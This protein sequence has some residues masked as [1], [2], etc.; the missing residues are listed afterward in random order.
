[1]NYNSDYI[2]EAIH[3]GDD[4]EIK[5]S[6]NLANVQNFSASVNGTHV[7]INSEGI[8]VNGEPILIGSSGDIIPSISGLRIGTN[9]NRWKE[10]RGVS[11]TTN[12]DFVV[13]DTVYATGISAEV[14]YS[15]L[16]IQGGILVAVFS[17]IFKD[18]LFVGT[19]LTSV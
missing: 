3:G 4:T 17:M 10:V 14:P 5:G 8:T 9:E 11:Y 19:T 13:D 2:D 18:G 1:M 6:Q 15:G 16:F 7:S 12:Y